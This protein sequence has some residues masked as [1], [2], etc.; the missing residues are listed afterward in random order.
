MLR[1]SNRRAPAFGMA[2]LLSVALASCGDESAEPS[3]S[4][5]QTVT[6]ACALLTAAEIEAATGI[7]PGESVDVS[8]GQLPMCNWPTADGSNVA[9]LTVLV[10]P[11]GNY[12]SYDEAVEKWAESAAAMDFPFDADEYQEV[13]GAGDVGAWI[14]NAGMLQAHSGDIMVQI[15]TDVAD[16]RDK[17][18][19]SR[20]LARSALERIP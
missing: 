15:L 6:D 2:L 16:G 11:S 14:A 4:P 9:F 1:L 5:T 12:K 7:V 20:E 8:Q 17:L 19:A 18:E 13:E 10:A 3:R